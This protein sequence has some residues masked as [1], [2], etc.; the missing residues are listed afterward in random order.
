MHATKM[1]TLTG[2]LALMAAVALAQS[3]DRSAKSSRCEG[4]PDTPA[5]PSALLELRLARHGDVASLELRG[6]APGSLAT[7]A[8]AESIA[9]PPTFGR[10][11]FDADGCFATAVAPER[12]RSG[13]FVAQGYGIGKDLQGSVAVQASNGLCVQFAEPAPTP[14]PAPDAPAP[15]AADFSL[16]RI[17]LDA[18]RSALVKNE[19]LARD[20]VGALGTALNSH[21]DTLLVKVSGKVM[22]AVPA[23]PV[24]VGGSVTYSAKIARDGDDYLVAIG[25]DVAVLCGVKAAKDVGV[26]GGVALGADQIHRFASPAEVAR[27]LLGIALQQALP[28]ALAAASG[29]N[30]ARV[31]QLRQRIDALVAA[32]EQLRARR[33]FHDAAVEHALDGALNA[34]A[35][36]HARTRRIGDVLDRAAGWVV[37]EAQFVR[38]HV[39]GAELRVSA[40]GEISL[41]IGDKKCGGRVG[42][43]LGGKVNGG[44][45]VTVRTFQGYG[46]EPRR[47][48]VLATHAVG[49]SF[50]A[51]AK[52]GSLAED[53]DRAFGRGFEISQKTTRGL[54]TVFTRQG[55]DF[56]PPQTSIVIKRE[57]GLLGFGRETTIEFDA[58]QLGTAGADALAALFDGQQVAALSALLPVIA[59]VSVQDKLTLALK[60]EFGVEDAELT[61]KVAAEGSWTDCGPQRSADLSLAS[62]LEQLLDVERTAAEVGQLV[63]EVLALPELQ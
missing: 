61:A 9:A 46:E 47:V 41:K 22:I 4:F 63:R 1:S 6:G 33:L 56:G 30:L 45:Q 62:V 10:G 16:L 43:E 19:V 29:E 40:T 32:I 55:A 14:A 27:G 13:T 53:N 31:R 24:Q 44:Y 51:G 48:E 5:V 23:T 8:I 20:F 7:I 50:A 57:F 18:S 59:H 12:L 60:P 54:R 35:V 42:A 34:L 21:G 49:G 17:E 11:V 2:A 38:D 37:D 3:P 26:E 15:A 28:G 52:L 36:V 25:E 58:A 39:D